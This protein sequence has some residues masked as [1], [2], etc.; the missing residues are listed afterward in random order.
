MSRPRHPARAVQDGEGA[1]DEDDQAGHVVVELAPL[2]VSEVSDAAAKS[3]VIPRP[4]ST[5]TKR[6][7]RSSETGSAEG[8]RRTTKKLSAPNTRMSA[9]TIIFV[10]TIIPYAVP[11]KP[12][13][14]ST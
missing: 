11:V 8:S 6:R 9:S 4:S 3:T 10:P 12:G 5:S 13:T 2:P 7:R 14:P 1:H